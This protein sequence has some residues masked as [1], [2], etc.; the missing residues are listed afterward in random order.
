[1]YQRMMHQPVAIL[2]PTWSSQQRRALS[3][4]FVWISTSGCSQHSRVRPLAPSGLGPVRHQWLSNRSTSPFLLSVF[5]GDEDLEF[6]ALA[7]ARVEACYT[8]FSK[9]LCNL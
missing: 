7:A 8:W 1:M 5:M 4:D 2:G 6:A 3:A 9:K